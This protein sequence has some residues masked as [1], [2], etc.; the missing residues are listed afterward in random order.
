MQIKVMVEK[1]DAKWMMGIQLLRL[2]LS[3]IE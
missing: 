3:C 1:D 2:L